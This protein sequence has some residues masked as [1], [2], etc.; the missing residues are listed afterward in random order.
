MKKIP[1]Y[2]KQTNYKSVA[3]R[4]ANY[5]RE[6]AKLAQMRANRYAGM[7]KI[8]GIDY[9]PTN[10]ALPP[11]RRVPIMEKHF[12]YLKRNGA[13]WNP[14]AKKWLRKPMVKHPWMTFT[15]KGVEVEDVGTAAHQAQTQL[16]FDTLF[17]KRE[18]G[19]V[20]P[21]ELGKMLGKVHR[22]K[23][24]T[25]DY[26]IPWR[27]IFKNAEEN[28]PQD[29]NETLTK[30]KYSIFK[31][32]KAEMDKKSEYEQMNEVYGTPRQKRICEDC[33]KSYYKCEC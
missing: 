3:E 19:T 7:R 28:Y 1:L 22:K 20:S 12:D 2:R 11:E 31:I 29:W 10:Y 15:D 24:H 30:M 4:K 6:Q 8:A 14:Y 9:E 27:T 21:M 25:D 32:A 33:G 16:L 26:I 18:I 13:Y 23:P 17:P 5:D